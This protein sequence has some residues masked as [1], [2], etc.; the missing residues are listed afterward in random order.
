MA[1]KKKRLLTESF[2]IEEITFADYTV[3]ACAIQFNIFDHIERG[4][5]TESFLSKFV[6]KNILRPLISALVASGYLQ[7]DTKSLITLSPISVKA[8]MILISSFSL[9]HFRT[10]SFNKIIL[11]AIIFL[12][13]MAE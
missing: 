7:Q 3:L 8:L 10:V 5:N 6:P 4:R 9:K 12:Y 13:Q 11:S 1:S 2:S